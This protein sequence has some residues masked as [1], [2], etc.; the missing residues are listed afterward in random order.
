MAL[1]EQLAGLGLAPLDGLHHR[2]GIEA[3]IA[4]QAIG[5]IEIN[6]DEVHR[7]VRLRLQD[8]LALELQRGADERG[9]H[10]GLAKQA[11]HRLRVVMAGEDG[12]ERIVQTDD[13]A[14]AIEILE[15]EGNNHVVAAFR[16]IEAIG[17]KVS[18]G[19]HHGK[20][21]ISRDAA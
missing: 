20:Q 17:R 6:D 2:I 5:R 10:H 15:G 19:G 9:Q 12:I 14:P 1:A 13:A 3:G 16:A 21:S 7:P 11:R 18:L 4:A 8:E